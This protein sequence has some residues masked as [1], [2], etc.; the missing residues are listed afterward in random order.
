VHIRVVLLGNGK[1][2]EDGADNV[3]QLS[4]TY[5]IER[6]TKDTATSA[7][8]ARLTTAGPAGSMCIA[9][10]VT[11][12]EWPSA[13]KMQWNNREENFRCLSMSNAG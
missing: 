10:D 3:I 5:A 1:Y 11:E 6:L 8:F 2:H 12:A 9:H 4:E 7:A 13:T